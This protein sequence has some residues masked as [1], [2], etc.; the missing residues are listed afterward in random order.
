[1]KRSA[2]ALYYTKAAGSF[3]LPEKSSWIHTWTQE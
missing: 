3:K 2:I 1:M